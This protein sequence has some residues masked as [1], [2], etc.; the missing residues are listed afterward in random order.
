M[1]QIPSPQP[2]KSLE[3]IGVLRTF[4][5]FYWDFVWQATFISSGIWTDLFGRRMG[6]EDARRTGS[7]ANGRRI[8]GEWGDFEL[9]GGRSGEKE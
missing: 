7:S 1:V 8:F 2:V 6:G 3:S 9:F 4:S 5:L